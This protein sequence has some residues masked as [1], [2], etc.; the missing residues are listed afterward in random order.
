MFLKV[1]MLYGLLFLLFI[2]FY[3]NIS[4]NMGCAGGLM[5][6]AF[7]YVIKNDGI[8]TEDSYPYVPRVGTHSKPQRAHDV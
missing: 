6:Q 8:D 7:E 5:D 1:L 4:G 3:C 2:I